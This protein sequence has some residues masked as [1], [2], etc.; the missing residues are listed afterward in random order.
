MFIICG[1][2]ASLYLENNMS[3]HGL[4]LDYMDGYFLHFVVYKVA[5]STVEVN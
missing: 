4:L 1:T 5:S 2:T 3:S